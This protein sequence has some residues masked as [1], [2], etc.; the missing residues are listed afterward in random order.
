MNITR[1]NPLEIE[2][3]YKDK[4]DPFQKKKKNMPN[5]NFNERKLIFK[6]S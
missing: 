4:A 3:E 1:S 5:D 2:F 6:V